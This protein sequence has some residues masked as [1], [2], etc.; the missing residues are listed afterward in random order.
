[1]Y[2]RD[3]GYYPVSTESSTQSNGNQGGL[4]SSLTG[5]I[6]LDGTAD[7]PKRGQPY[8]TFKKNDLDSSGKVLLDPWGNAYIYIAR[9]YVTNWSTMAFDNVSGS[10][11]PFW[12]N[13]TDVNQNTY[14]IYSLGSDGKANGN[15][16][17]N[18]T[19]NYATT[20]FDAA[21]DGN[22]EKTGSYTGDSYNDDDLN[23]WSGQ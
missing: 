7:T 11:G 14:N 1:M 2:K 22:N 21:A 19:G 6:K 10:Y 8:I 16:A 18:A 23:S 13:T 15:L 4:A 20:Y 12:P 3:W 9:E 17:G 5:S